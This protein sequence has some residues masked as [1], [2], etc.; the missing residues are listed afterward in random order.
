MYSPYGGP[1]DPGQVT[2]NAANGREG[3]NRL[4]GS[5][6][7]MGTQDNGPSFHTPDNVDNPQGPTYQPMQG[8]A[9]RSIQP[10]PYTEIP[11][12][13]NSPAHARIRSK[14]SEI[15]AD[16]ANG[17]APA[18]IDASKV[19]VDFEK[20]RAR[21]ERALSQRDYD[22]VNREAEALQKRIQQMKD[23]STDIPLTDK[24]TIMNMSHIADEAAQNIRDGSDTQQDAVIQ[25]GL[26]DL[27]QAADGLG[28]VTGAAPKQNN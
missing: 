5:K 8:S 25:M 11:N 7:R 9:R 10:P 24:L 18:K 26:Q 19:R 23:N 27:D 6:T 17:I 14:L 4:Q 12:M 22:G 21:L 16:Q 13:E 20:T 28:R 15:Y 1:Q 2:P 3:F